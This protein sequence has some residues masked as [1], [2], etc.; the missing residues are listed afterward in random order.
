MNVELSNAFL[1]IIINNGNG[2]ILHILLCFTLLT[3]AKVEHIST[4]CLFVKCQ[5]TV[6]VNLH[7]LL[8]YISLLYG[9]INLKTDNVV[10]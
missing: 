1:C 9:Y 5:E 6:T 2:L 7:S 10:F 8:E 3:H 4:D